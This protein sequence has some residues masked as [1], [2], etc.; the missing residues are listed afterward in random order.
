MSRLR[1]ALDGFRPPVFIPLA[2]SQTVELVASIA[3]RPRRANADKNRMDELVTALGQRTVETLSRAALRFGLWQPDVADTAAPD[4]FQKLIAEA[5]RRDDAP[6]ARAVWAAYLRTFAPEGRATDLLAGALEAL[7]PRLSPRIADPIRAFDLHR[8]Q[9]ALERVSASLA[10]PS[11][12]ALASLVTM[13]PSVQRSRLGACAAAGTIEA[14]AGRSDDIERVLRSMRDREGH[15][16]APLTEYLYP[17]LVRPY[18]ERPPNESVKQR[19][20][21]WIREAY[22]DPRLPT[23]SRPTLAEPHLAEPCVTAVRRWLAIETLHLFIEVI[24]S[25]ADAQWEHRR[26]FWLPYFQSNFVT[27]VHVAFGTQGRD[28]ATLIRQRK[29]QHMRWAALRGAQAGQSVLLMRIGSLIVAEWSHA[30][31]V[32][33]WPQSDPTAPNLRRGQFQATDLRDGSMMVSDEFGRV[34]DGFRHVAY[35]KWCDRTA[36]VIAE[37]TGLKP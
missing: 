5:L 34:D 17:A 2:P 1:D 10:A 19:V 22:G 27:E 15:I 26:D 18:L 33:F 13:R 31:K 29:N 3:P 14:L 8:P 7:L 32:R 9:Q 12:D 20:I 36:R 23:T 24:N 6:S 28:L 21:G 16:A 37:H 4:G 25:T 11:D 30:G 35:P